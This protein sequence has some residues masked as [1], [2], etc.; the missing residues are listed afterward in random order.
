MQNQD[1]TIPGVVFLILVLISVLGIKLSPLWA[2][3]IGLGGF[4]IAYFLL[5]KR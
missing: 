2:V 3:L 1:H 4:G 5:N